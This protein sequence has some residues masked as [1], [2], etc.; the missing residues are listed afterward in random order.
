MNEQELLSNLRALGEENS[1]GAPPEVEQFLLAAF[2]QRVRRRRLAFWGSAGTGLIAAGLAVFALTSGH[3]VMMDPPAQT[4]AVAQ[5]SAG[6]Q[7]AAEAL[8]ASAPMVNETVVRT[9]EVSQSFYPLPEAE[10]LP[11][12]DDV[13]VVRVQ[14]TAGS[15]ELMGLPLNE[16]GSDPVQADLLLGQDGLARGVRVI[17]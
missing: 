16:T 9:D 1:A 15:L 5:Q 7:G 13:M 12:A 4:A 6:E 3:G 2:R 8:D 10:G 11:P 14:L 17:E